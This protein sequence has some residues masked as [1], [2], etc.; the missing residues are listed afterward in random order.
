MFKQ[1]WISVLI[2]L[3]GVVWIGIAAQSF[4]TLNVRQYHG[5]TRIPQLTAALDANFAQLAADGGDFTVGGTFRATKASILTGVVTTA[6]DVNNDATGGSTSDPDFDA[7]GYAKFNGT[8]EA[9]ATVRTKASVIFENLPSSDPGVQ[10]QLY[11]TA[12]GTMKISL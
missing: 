6:A 7:D 10:G 12:A 4:T 9:A 1:T 8:L 5:K 2:V 11:R 3:V